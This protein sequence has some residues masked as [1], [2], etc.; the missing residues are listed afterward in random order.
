MDRSYR[1]YSVSAL[2]H[3]IGATSR[4]FASDLDA[5]MFAALLTDADHGVE[6]WQTDRLVGRMEPLAQS[7]A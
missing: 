5:L 7:A 4:E 3:I 1:L 6:L 2:G